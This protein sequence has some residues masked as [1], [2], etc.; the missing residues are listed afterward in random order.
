MTDQETATD[1]G[2]RKRSGRNLVGQHQD[3]IFGPAPILPGESSAAYHKLLERVLADA[4]P[5]DII[6]EILARDCVYLSWEIARLRRAKARFI[7]DKIPSCLGDILR[8]HMRKSSVPEQTEVRRFTLVMSSPSPSPP[9]PRPRPRP[10][11]PAYKLAQKW[12]VGDPDATARVEKLLASRKLV[13][14]DVYARVFT[15]YF[16][17]IERIDQMIT[18]FERRRNAVFREIDRH[19]SAFAQSLRSEIHQ[20]EDAEFETIETDQATPKSTDHKDAA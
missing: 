9:P 20:I 15:R 5:I 3:S 4:K 10:I 16:A 12:A 18:D 13:M 1:R 6:F 17:E 11:H 7:A 14:D 8:S 2:S 19:R